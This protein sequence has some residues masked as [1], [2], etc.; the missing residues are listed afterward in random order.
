MRED[1]RERMRG[2]EREDEREGLRE[3]IKE[4]VIEAVQVPTETRGVVIPA[5]LGV[6]EALQQ[7]CDADELVCGCVG[8]WVCVGWWWVVGR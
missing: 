6:A 8:V 4:R 2:C 5:G 1:K 7:R 3:R